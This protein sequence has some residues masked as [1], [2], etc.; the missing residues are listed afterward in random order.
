MVPHTAQGEGAAVTEIEVEGRICQ[1]RFSTGK[2]GK[3]RVNT[4]IVLF[5]NGV[6]QAVG[7]LLARRVRDHPELEQGTLSFLLCFILL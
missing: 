3:G 6:Q 7:V 4:S 2:R 1:H 5:Q